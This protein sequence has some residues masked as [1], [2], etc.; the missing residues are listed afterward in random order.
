[1]VGKRELES[2][3][4]TVSHRSGHSLLRAQ[5]TQTQGRVLWIHVEGINVRV[6]LKRDTMAQALI[7][8]KQM[9]LVVSIE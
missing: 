3:A 7:S 1:M 6:L 4:C 5:C 8:A 9:C 2:E